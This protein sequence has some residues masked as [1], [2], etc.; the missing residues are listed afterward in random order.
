MQFPDYYTPVAGAYS[1]AERDAMFAKIRNADTPG[2]LATY[3]LANSKPSLTS[4]TTPVIDGEAAVG[5]S[6]YAARAN[7]V[8][9]VDTGR[10]SHNA[11]R[12]AYFKNP[13]N[14]R[15]RGTGSANKVNSTDSDPYIID[16]WKVTSGYAYLTSSGM[17]LN[18]TI[19]QVVDEDLS[20]TWTG[21]A[22]ASDGAITPTTST[23]NKTFSIS[24]SG[25]TLYA[26]KWE[27]RSSQTLYTGRGSSAVLVDGQ[28]D[29]GLE[30]L[31]CQRYEVVY[32]FN[33]FGFGDGLA[34]TA[35]GTGTTNAIAVLQLPASLRGTPTSVIPTSLYLF[36]GANFNTVTAAAVRSLAGNQLALEL[37]TYAATTAAHPYFLYGQ[38][39]GK[40]VI[41]TY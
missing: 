18:G 28:P 34:F 13:I 30:L 32:N 9:P 1:P 38:I 20:G 5:S 40:L 23:A 15:G 7:H 41:T 26:A 10:Q 31:R 24:A 27:K 6:T 3:D 12:N 37:T 36:D 11:L 29:I 17:Y 14:S 4:G 33:D 8:H 16:G 21:S 19:Q 22:L 25:K 35:L 2:N 39:G